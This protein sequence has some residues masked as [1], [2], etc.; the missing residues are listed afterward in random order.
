MP[1]YICSNKTEHVFDKMTPDGFCE[2]PECYGIGFLVEV[3]DNS[4][5]RQPESFDLESDIA[6]AFFQQEIGL[7]I[8][9]MDASGSM[10]YQA[11]PNS[12][13]LKEHLIAGSA[14]GGIFDLAQTTN[15]ENAYVCG[16]MFDTE[17]NLIFM[18]TVS[19]ILKKYSSPGAFAG[20]LKERFHEMHGGTDINKA[21]GFAK[22]IYDDFMNKGDLSK[23]NGPKNVKPILHTIFDRD[24]KERIIPNIRVLIYT[25]GMETQSSKI[26]NPFKNEEVDVLMGS[27]FGPGEEEGCKALREILSR[28]PKHDIEQFFLI[29]DPGRIQTLRK[30]FRMASGASGFCP[31]CLADAAAAG[32]DL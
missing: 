25:D 18:E 29:N 22:E 21:L 14:S 10:E 5:E 1:K 3:P 7:C 11:F 24:N 16:I 13:V 19:D 12:P 2:K 17:T 20:F 15:K 26:V 32:K 30:L 4:T 27:Y 9:V 6:P 28:C 23:Y 8:I 31:M